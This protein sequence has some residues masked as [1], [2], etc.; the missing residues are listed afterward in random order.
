MTMSRRNPLHLLLLC[1]A[2]GGCSANTPAGGRCSLDGDCAS[3]VCSAATGECLPI[4]H[5]AP[6]LEVWPPSQNNQGWVVQEF[7]KGTLKP[8]GEVHVQLAAGVSLEGQVYASDLDAAGGKKLIP[9]RI[10][11]WRDSK[12]EG[13][14]PVQVE[15]TVTPSQREGKTQGQTTY[16]LWLARGTYTAYVVPLEP[17]DALYPPVVVNGIKVED[18]LKQDFVLDGDDRAVDVTGRVVDAA[19]KPLVRDKTAVP[20][21]V[22]AFRP[23]GLGYSTLGSADAS[24]AFTFK[25][26]A[27]VESYTVRV[28]RAPDGEPIPTMECTGRVLGIMGADQKQAIGDLT[29]PPFR[30]AEPYAVKVV[31]VDDLPVAQATVTFTTA[32]A[33]SAP[34]GYKE[35]S[36][37]FTQSGIT[38]AEGKVTL[39]LLPGDAKNRSYS[40]TVVSPASSPHASQWLA[41]VE[42][43]PQ[44]GALQAFVLD[45]RYVLR[46]RVEMA[47][48]QPVPGAMIEAGAIASG[49]ALSALPPSKASATTDATGAFELH[50]DPGVYNIDIRPPV[51]L[52]L[53]AFGLTAKS[54]QGNLDGVLFTVPEAK[55]LRGRILDPSGRELP[56]AQVKVY[57]LVPELEK[58]L[59]HKA[60]L[61]GSSVTDPTGSFALLLPPSLAD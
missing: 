27:G 23:G 20:V 12:L 56:S 44:G 29:L 24:G 31:G 33:V 38:D 57:D 11:V 21:R 55:A 2:L 16:V 3:G 50:V 47:G 5:K 10:V 52:A 58:P 14:P 30:F 45:R 42:V 4:T 36:A 43:G 18:H 53:P 59:K 26:P 48:A 34:N 22:R 60:V 1:F 9:A 54:I 32:L 6:G 35:C 49:E 19:G 46:G 8:N 39:K 15:T 7:P 41:S 37:S 17:Y 28:E 25:V 40:V 61:R 13:R 51:D